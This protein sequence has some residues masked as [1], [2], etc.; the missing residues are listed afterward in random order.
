MRYSL[1]VT[2]WIIWFLI[3]SHL[4]LNLPRK[5]FDKHNVDR[6]RADSEQEVWEG[7]IGLEH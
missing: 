1:E 5:E 3:F 2:N 6:G 7:S 4:L